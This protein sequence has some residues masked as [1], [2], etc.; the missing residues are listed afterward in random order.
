MANVTAA[1]Q[2]AITTAGP[3]RSVVGYLLCE[4]QRVLTDNYA[5]EFTVVS[6]ALASTLA[7]STTAV[8][9]RVRDYGVEHGS[10]NGTLR[11]ALIWAAYGD[12]GA[13]E[14]VFDGTSFLAPYSASSTSSPLTAPDGKEFSIVRT[15]GWREDPT[16][17]CYAIDPQANELNNTTTLA[18]DFTP[19]PAD[20]T[21]PVLAIVSPASGS[22]LATSTTACVVSVVDTGSGYGNAQIWVGFS[23][24]GAKEMAYDGSAFLAPYSVS[25]SVSDIANG[26]QFSLVR[27]GGWRE[28]PQVSSRKA[29]ALGNA[30]TSTLTAWDF[31]P[32]PTPITALVSVWDTVTS[33]LKVYFSSAPSTA[34]TSKYD[35]A[36]PAGSAN[37]TVNSYTIAGNAVILTLSGTPDPGSYT[38]T[39]TA[40]AA[41]T[42]G[43]NASSVASLTFSGVDISAPTVANVV[44]AEDTELAEDDPIQ[45]DVLD[46]HLSSVTLH[47]LYATIGVM[48]TV[49][50]THPVDGAKFGPQYTG[51]VSVISGGKRFSNV[52]RTTGWP[53]APEII[54]DPKDTSGN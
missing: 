35:I 26:K 38:L 20:T 2:R 46:A 22:T 18:W 44:P 50:Y 24:G 34:D 8:V 17:H 41:T 49:Y 13:P 45:F 7:T 28:D 42:S 1:Q 52:Q 21:P 32:T 19:T 53:A 30:S 23:D 14:M 25:S 9:V 31:T 4:A 29:D 3:D 40:G 37:L 51:T 10:S 36:E 11:R 33:K 27:T 43:G 16:L 54:V 5:P 48:E 12:G 6:P 15:G 39:L 47:A